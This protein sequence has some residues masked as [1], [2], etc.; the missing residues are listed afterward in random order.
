[1]AESLKGSARHL[2]KSTCAIAWIGIQL[3]SS[4]IAASKSSCNAARDEPKTT[5]TSYLERW[6]S[7]R[8]YLTRNQA[9]GIPVPR[10]RIPPS[11]PNARRAPRG[12][13]LFWTGLFWP[14]PACPGFGLWACLAISSVSGMRLGCRAAQGGSGGW[15]DG[16]GLVRWPSVVARRDWARPEPALSVPDLTGPH[17]RAP[18]CP[19]AGR[20]SH[21]Q[22]LAKPVPGAGHAGSPKI[23]PLMFR[24]GSFPTLPPVA[25]RHVIPPSLESSNVA[26]VRL[27]RQHGPADPA[28]HVPDACLPPSRADRR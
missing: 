26:A 3:R 19:R 28:W 25:A 1:M 16:G 23:E 17:P 20:P 15:Q 14:I 10:V 4:L 7:G 21:G 5:A 18:R 13:F 11:P 9:Y 24:H 2:K 22:S 27:G 12:P 6:Q 8:L